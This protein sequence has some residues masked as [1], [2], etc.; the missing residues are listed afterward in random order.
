[1]EE[2]NAGRWV[3]WISGSF[4]G[5]EDRV[6]AAEGAVC[7]AETLRHASPPLSAKGCRTELSKQSISTCARAREEQSQTVASPF[8]SP[9]HAKLA[10][11]RSLARFHPVWPQSVGKGGGS[12]VGT[13]PALALG[14]SPF[15]GRAS[16]LSLPSPLQPSPVR[17][18][19][20]QLGCRAHVNA[21]GGEAAS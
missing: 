21:D 16:F 12:P 11:A 10:R 19:T 7:A 9:T 15:G 18:Q 4:G 6:R 8:P 13:P 3:L 1:M 20:S 5:G 14:R 17:K 2:T